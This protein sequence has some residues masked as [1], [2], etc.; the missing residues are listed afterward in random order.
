MAEISIH[1]VRDLGEDARRALEALLGRRLGEEEQISV[2]VLPPRPAP[3]GEERRIAAERLS[4]TLEA[5]SERAREIPAEELEELIDA[6]M[7]DV[8]RRR[9]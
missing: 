1:N 8:R 2:T 7:D 6:A 4:K 5:M 9:G 3:S